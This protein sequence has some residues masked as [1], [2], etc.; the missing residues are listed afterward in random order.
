MG[1]VSNR[2]FD[3]LHKVIG[4]A[5]GINPRIKV[6]IVCVPLLLLMLFLTPAWVF[7]IFVGAVAA[8]SAVEFSMAT[9]T[10]GNI[11]ILVYVAVSAFVIPVFLSL[12]M[13]H[14]M[15]ALFAALLLILT[16]FVES[17]LAYGTEQARPFSSVCANFFAGA[18]IPLF[19]GML[20]ILRAIPG[21]ILPAGE[22]GWFFDG[23]VYVLI[24]FT[25][26][27]ISD[28][29][30]YF[31]GHAFGQHKLI[32]RVS[33]KKTIE[34]SVGGFAA[35]LVAMLIFCFVLILFFDAEFN[36]LAVF[37]YSIFGSAITQIGDLAFSLIK[38]E[39]GKKDFGNLLPGHGGML[40][41][42]DSMIFLAPFI[43]ALVF[44]LPIFWQ[45]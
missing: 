39:Y 38:R 19:L 35:A 16:L 4:G 25:I 33:P 21:G 30:G 28:A 24:P 9:K 34:G 29:G 27:F 41:R 11:R 8:I 1:D 7:G 12:P 22:L 37:L 32:E 2:F 36:L 15:A 26:A 31:A 14:I 40:D 42:F 5:G 13:L 17:I 44:W 3:A 20:S 23:R 18:V 43:T 10:A 45:G 6:A